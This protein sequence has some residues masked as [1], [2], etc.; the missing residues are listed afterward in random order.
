MGLNKID[1]AFGK[2]ELHK[3]RDFPLIFS[4]HP[5]ECIKGKSQF[6]ANMHLTPFQ[7]IKLP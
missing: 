1:I 5:S 6:G 3:M 2:M 7:H 4:F